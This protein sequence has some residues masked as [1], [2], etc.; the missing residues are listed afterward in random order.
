M[1]L[2]CPLDNSEIWN[3]LFTWNIKFVFKKTV[4]VKACCSFKS[5]ATLSRYLDPD[6]YSTME[7]STDLLKTKQFKKL[8][9]AICG[10]V[11]EY[12]F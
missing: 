11:S 8:T 6:M 12:Y 3:I 4:N 7:D 2:S 10:L 5:Y 1:A 9:K